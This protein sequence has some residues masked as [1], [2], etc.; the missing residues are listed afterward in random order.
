MSSQAIVPI[1]QRPGFSPSVFKIDVY[2]LPPPLE[3]RK[4]NIVTAEQ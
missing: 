3:S 2:I 1:K 4:V